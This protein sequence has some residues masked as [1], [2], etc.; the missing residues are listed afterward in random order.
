METIINTTMQSA[1][2]P[3][4]IV[5]PATVLNVESCPSV[6]EATNSNDRT[7]QIATGA[8]MVGGGIVG[9]ILVGYFVGKETAKRRAAKVRATADYETMEQCRDVDNDEH[10]RAETVASRHIKGFTD[11]ID[12]LTAKLKNLG[13]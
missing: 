13:K 9:G 1:T 6:T 10:A 4:T 8:A 11:K 7:K 2:D 3:M 12:E 5:D